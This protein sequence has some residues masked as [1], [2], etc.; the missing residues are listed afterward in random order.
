MKKVTSVLF[1]IVSI[2]SIAFGMPEIVFGISLAAVTGSVAATMDNAFVGSF[3]LNLRKVYPQLVARYGDQGAEFIGMLM[4][5]GW[6]AT[7]DV[8]SIQHFEDQWIWD[9]FKVNAQA[10]GPPNGP[11]NLVVNAESIDTSGYF[12]PVAKDIIE[13]PRT[14]GSADPVWG[15]IESITGTTLTVK[16]MK[17]GTSIPATLAGQEL[18]IVTNG[19]SEGSG[20][21]APKARGAYLYE[22]RFAIGK[23]SIEATGSE[24][25]TK[26]W[27]NE[28]NGKKIGAW[29]DVALSF[30]LD[31][32]MMQNIQGWFLGGQENDNNVLDPDNNKEVKWTKGLFPT[33]NEVS[34][35][36]PYITFGIEDFDQIERGLSKVYAGTYT[37][38][39]LGLEAD[40]E[41]EN[42]L[43]TY[44]NFTNIDYITKQGNESIFKGDA[45]LA[46]AVGF[47]Y[48]EKAKRK[49]A[50]K[51]FSSFNNPKTYNASGYDYVT[52]AMMFPLRSNNVVSLQNGTKSTIPAMRV[53]YKA[54]GSYNRKMEMFQTGSSDAARWGVT[55]DVDT[56]LW[57]QRCEF[58]A[59]FFAANQFVNIFKANG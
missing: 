19:N 15:Y 59:E 42:A 52:R 7:L 47:S 26:T 10:G 3:D 4:A 57:H 55:N 1:I 36:H 43:K 40:I 13:F 31:Y 21:P 23:A 54:L 58:G 22:N 17:A 5:M 27:V 6:D 41:I 18:I 12:F 37:A 2:L 45:G 33:M 9:S 25:T 16:P 39:M 14:A 8:T 46:L 49:Y 24:M 44:M 38:C 56:R 48:F 34:I 51:R 30:D 53:V 29:Y 32:R 28:Y 20:Q 50:M 35:Q 11:V